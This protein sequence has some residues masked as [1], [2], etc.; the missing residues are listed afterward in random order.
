MSINPFYELVQSGF[1]FARRSE[2][3]R[4]RPAGVRR[5]PSVAPRLEA[6]SV[7]KHGKNP[8][9]SRMFGRSIEG[10]SRRSQATARETIRAQLI[11]EINQQI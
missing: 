1:R 9:Y 3:D 7:Y 6:L 10:R 8:I 2:T 11:R 5:V 4:L